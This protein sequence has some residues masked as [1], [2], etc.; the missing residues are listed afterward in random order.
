MKI[1][2]IVFMFLALQSNGQSN[3][4]IE[5][6]QRQEA[7]SIYG[8][9]GTVYLVTPDSSLVIDT[10]YQGVFKKNGQPDKKLN[11]KETLE[12]AIQF[13]RYLTRLSIKQTFS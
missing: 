13:K 10:T 4:A 1:L 11:K 8:H 3:P 7:F 2:F 9:W 6:H 12:K 5:L